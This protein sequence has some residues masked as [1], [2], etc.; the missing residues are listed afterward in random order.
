MLSG[1]RR[2]VDRILLTVRTVIKAAQKL[3]CVQRFDN[4]RRNGKITAFVD[5]V[6]IDMNTVHLTGTGE[7][8]GPF[9][10]FIYAVFHNIAA[11][12]ADEKVQLTEVMGMHDM[13]ALHRMLLGNHVI[14]PN[15]SDNITF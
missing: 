11:F 4:L 12:T 1:L 13:P 8:H 15:T 14:I 3:R 10:R 6:R 7:N 5:T 9:A 2:K